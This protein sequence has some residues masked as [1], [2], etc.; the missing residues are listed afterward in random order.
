LTILLYE[1]ELFSYVYITHN[2]TSHTEI[3]QGV[4]GENSSPVVVTTSS[5]QGDQTVLVFLKRLYLV[6]FGMC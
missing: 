2:S 6:Y 3:E 5:A 1:A 4:A